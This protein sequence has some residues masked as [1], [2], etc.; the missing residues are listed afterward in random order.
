[1]IKTQQFIEKARRIHGDKYD[2]SVSE[3]KGYQAKIDIR[4]PDHG[5]F[6]QKPSGH[7]HGCGCPKCG[8]IL[9]SKSNTCTTDKFIVKAIRV[10]G[11]RYDYSRVIYSGNETKVLI[12]CPKHGYF[13]QTPHGHLKGRICKKCAMEDLMES[14]KVTLLDFVD[15]ARNIHGDTYDYSH[16]E[17]QDAHT[18]TEIVCKKHGSFYQTPNDHLSGYG[19]PSCGYEIV[20]EKRTLSQEE[21]I[22]RVKEIYKDEDYNYEKTTYVNALTDV[23]VTCPK[24]GD[25]NQNAHSFLQGHGCQ[26]C[27]YNTYTLSECIERFKEIHGNT[28]DYSKM[29]YYNVRTKVCIICPEHGEFW[30]RPREHFEGGG[31]P[32]CNISYGELKIR[33]WLLNN[34]IHFL[35][36][37]K[38]EKL[39]I[40]KSL[41]FDFYLPD[42]KVA[43]EY[44]GEQHFR[45]VRF[46]G[47]SLDRAIK[48]YEYN[49][50]RDNVKNKFCKD[51]HILLLRIR[52]DYFKKIPDILSKSLK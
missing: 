43:I 16:A 30:K 47:V 13:L 40:N 39:K 14:T 33:D 4:C 51:N 1:M 21:F 34:H 50:V 42:K 29:I 9:R 49:K 3:Y 8:N 38:F 41:K 18:K 22:K 7:I 26:R 44:D 27:G 31:C 10:H 12:G 6:K 37:H 24:H 48:I 11:D 36:Q 46:N 20:S 2:Y 25:F 32:N 5:I 28:Y 15:K 35:Q 23:I 17:Y 45:P 19:C 52:Y